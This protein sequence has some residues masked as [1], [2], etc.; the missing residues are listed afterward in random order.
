MRREIFSFCLVMG[1]AL[2]ASIYYHAIH[3][4]CP[5][6][7]TGLQPASWKK[8]LTSPAVSLNALQLGIGSSY[9]CDLFHLFNHVS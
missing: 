7:S 3:V 9:Y 6:L 1:A 5:Q 8:I 4:Q 2:D